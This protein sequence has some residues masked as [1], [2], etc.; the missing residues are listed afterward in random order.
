MIS[1]QNNGV[2]IFHAVG[3]LERCY[4]TKCPAATA[5]YE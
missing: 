3:E 5:L 1:P 2:I 4:S